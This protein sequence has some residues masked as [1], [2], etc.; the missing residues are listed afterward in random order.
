MRD[1]RE[2]STGGA[3]ER[4]RSVSH[5]LK[6]ISQQYQ[7]KQMNNEERPASQGPTATPRAA[8]SDSR[9]TIGSALRFA[10]PLGRPRARLLVSQSALPRPTLR[11]THRRHTP[12]PT[13]FFQNVRSPPAI[14]SF[15]APS[16]LPLTL[17]SNQKSKMYT[18]P[19]APSPSLVLLGHPRL[20][21]D[22]LH[23]ALVLTPVLLVQPRRLRIRGR[24]RVRV[25]QQGL[26]RGEDGRDVVDG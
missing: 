3:R 24:A 4:L 16:L 15:L 10:S 2:I 26:D 9:V 19:P 13:A 18:W 21:H 17:L 14:S 5:H 25:T 7:R 20:F 22:L 6:V 23:F 12:L 1:A 8:Q 11:A